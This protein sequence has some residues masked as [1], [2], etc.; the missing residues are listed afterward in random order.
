MKPEKAHCTAEKRERPLKPRQAVAINLGGLG[1]GVVVM[2]LA[3]VLYLVPFWQAMMWYAVGAFFILAF[4]WA[5]VQW[6]TRNRAIRAHNRFVYFFVAMMV[7]TVVAQWGREGTP[8]P[9]WAIAVIIAAGIA[10]YSVMA[11]HAI[12]NFRR[13]RHGDFREPD[14]KKT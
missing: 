13:W 9:K 12:A 3:C 1:I 14:G 10:A 5:C 6:E 11:Y 2:I 7:V 4:P 8:F